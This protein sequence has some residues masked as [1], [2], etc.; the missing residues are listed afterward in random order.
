MISVQ[1]F[2]RFKEIF[3]IQLVTNSSQ[4]THHNT[5]ERTC[6]SFDQTVVT[7]ENPLSIKRVLSRSLESYIKH[8]K[9]GIFAKRMS[10]ELAKIKAESE[11]RQAAEEKVD[12]RKRNIL[13]LILHHLHTNG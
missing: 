3:Q 6:L 9:K 8:Y 1:T 10:M 12:T 7:K 11:A 13:V 5:K 4:H 2:V